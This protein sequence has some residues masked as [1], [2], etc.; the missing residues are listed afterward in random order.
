MSRGAVSLVISRITMKTLI[1]AAIRCSLMFVAVTASLV[2]IQPAQAARI[3]G[4]IEFFG[5][6]KFDTTNFLN[7]TQVVE[8]RAPNIGFTRV[9]YTTGDFSASRCL[10]RRL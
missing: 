5:E 1:L 4:E 6:A 10:L 7:A 2:S 8:W 3:V 9:G